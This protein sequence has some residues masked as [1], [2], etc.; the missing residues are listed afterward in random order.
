MARK[1]KETSSVE[2]TITEALNQPTEDIP[3]EEP[4]SPL[5]SPL[6]EPVAE[7]DIGFGGTTSSPEP[8]SEIESRETPEEEASEDT[9]DPFDFDGADEDGVP[10]QDI[11]TG[12]GS[13]WDMEEADGSDFELPASHARQAADTVLGMADNVMAIG[14]G[15]FIKIK[16]HKD[17]YDFEE[18]IQIIDEQNEK[19]TRRLKLDEEDKVLLRPLLIAILKKRAKR[20]T[21]E[22]QLVGA[23]LSILM[24]KVQIVV[25]IRAENEILVERILD[26]IRA[27]KGNPSPEEQEEPPTDDHPFSQPSVPDEEE[28]TEQFE[29][30]VTEMVPEEM[31]S[32]TFADTVLEVAA[33]DDEQPDNTT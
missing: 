29:T 10:E 32:D 7:N 2:Q 5:E 33:D 12:K 28:S 9:E 31:P 30:T 20:L 27:E 8:T 3:F 21:P 11:G 19:N 26:V 15:F 24:K 17:F 14:G 4:L 25:E 18:V 13:H 22:Q 1:K 23:V 6:N 16:K